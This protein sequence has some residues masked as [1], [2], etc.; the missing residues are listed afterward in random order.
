[1]DGMMMMMYVCACECVDVCVSVNIYLD[2]F[3][4]Q[5]TPPTVTL[6]ALA[7][8]HVFGVLLM[9]GYVRV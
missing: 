6:L 3:P 2:S 5:G 8:G 4:W 1:M 7:L 9:C